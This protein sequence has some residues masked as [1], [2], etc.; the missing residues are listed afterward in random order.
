MA[1]TYGCAPCP[2][3]SRASDGA[4]D[5]QEDNGADGGRDQAA[6]EIL[7]YGDVKLGKEEAADDGAY[8]ADRELMKDTAAA[9][10]DHVREPA[11]D[12]ADY[13]PGDDAHDVG[14][15]LLIRHPSRLAAHAAHTSG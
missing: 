1:V 12:Q 14:S 2:A 8:Q 15:L 10:Q 5:S 11:G 13:D 3:R 7:C 4:P 9:T 6:P